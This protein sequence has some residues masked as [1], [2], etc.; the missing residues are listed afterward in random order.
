MI[1]N[2]RKQTVGLRAIPQRLS[3]KWTW[4][5]ALA[6][7]VVWSVG[8]SEGEN[9]DDSDSIDTPD[10]SDAPPAESVIKK[11]KGPFV[12]K[13]PSGWQQFKWN[14]LMVILKETYLVHLG[15]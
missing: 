5:I 10:T 3:E 1:S 4:K 11:K 12:K 2:R 9:S 14:P 6:I 8:C 13:E 7:V 15:W